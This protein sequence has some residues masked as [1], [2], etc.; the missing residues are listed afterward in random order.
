MELKSWILFNI[1]G[2][3]IE[4]GTDWQKSFRNIDLALSNGLY[5]YL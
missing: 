3:V 4:H 1:C 5:K 2:E